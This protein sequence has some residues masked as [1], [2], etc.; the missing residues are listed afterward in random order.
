[1]LES[2][3][4]GI[5]AQEGLGIEQDYLKVKEPKKKG[6]WRLKR[7]SPCLASVRPEFNP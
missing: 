2:I 3:N 5:R 7:W 1:M 6:W 4:Q